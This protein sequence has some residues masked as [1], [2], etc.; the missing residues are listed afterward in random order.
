MSQLEFDSDQVI[1][2]L[3]NNTDLLKTFVGSFGGTMSVES[4]DFLDYCHDEILTDATKI[5]YEVA[6]GSYPFHFSVMEHKGVFFVNGLEL[7]DFGYFLK[8]EHAVTK[9]SQLAA[10]WPIENY[11]DDDEDEDIE[12]RLSDPLEAISEEQMEAISE[13]MLGRGLVRCCVPEDNSE[14]TRH[15]LEKQKQQKGKV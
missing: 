7:G 15:R 5:H 2:H 13:K 6:Y 12:E 1:A 8:K 9:A 10:E 4:Q 14:F 3:I 11:E